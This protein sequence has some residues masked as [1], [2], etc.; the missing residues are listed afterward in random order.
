VPGAIAFLAAAAPVR[1]G[2]AM[3]SLGVVWLIRGETGSFAVAGSVAG[4]FAITE[5]IV[6]P[7]SSRLIDRH[8]QT[9]V[10]PW[11]LGAHALAVTLLV[12]SA[13]THRSTWLL[14]LAGVTAGASI[15]QVGALSAA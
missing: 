9:R 7:Q 4:A 12:G 8:G 10:L 3:T 2:I 11:L 14:I 6:G 5:A 1:I 15:P 13:V